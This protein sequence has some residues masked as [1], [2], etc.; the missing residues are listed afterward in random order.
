MSKNV[1]IAGGGII[2]LC[3]AY[4]LH[5]EGH[6]VTVTDGSAMTGGASYVNAG[7]ITPSHI[8]PLAAPGVI[9]KGLKWMFNSASPFYMKPRFDPEFFK[10]VWYF[11]RSSTAANV[12]K[13]IP[14]IKELN[15]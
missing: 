13:A 7:Y 3:A 1:I 2:G 10:W 9:T 6:K 12:Q 5:K 4:Y 15:L 8:I 11:K 14:L